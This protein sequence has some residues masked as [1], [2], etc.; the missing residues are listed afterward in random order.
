MMACL[1]SMKPIGDKRHRLLIRRVWDV[2][3]YYTVCR[4]EN[5]LVL[6]APYQRLGKGHMSSG[7]VVTASL[8]TFPVRV[9]QVRY[10]V[11]SLLLQTRRPDKIIL[12]LAESQFPG[13][14]TPENLRDLC[15]YGLEIRFCD[16]LRSHKKYYYT[17]QEQRENEL[18]VT[19]DDDII[20]HPHTIE[21][22]LETHKK[23]PE[24]IICSQVRIMTFDNAGK[25]NPY[26][27]W[28]TASD[29]M[30]APDKNH[31]PLTG[32]GCLYPYG[33]M[34]PVTF[35]KEKIR[36][37]AP[38][39]DDLWIGV[40]ARMNGT[41]ICIPEKVARIFS[42][43]HDSQTENLSQVNCIGDGNDATLARLQKEFGII[44]Q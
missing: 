42:V 2:L 12:W 19:F 35:D 21:R 4:I 3:R 15:A 30:D 6:R 1:E 36:T 40:L 5:W 26:N 38:T 33:V 23:H 17:L 10:S 14:Q 41:L 11:I 34:P 20:Y 27:Q 44:A 13:R 16:D 9:K 39:A 43:V 31:T 32:S 7:K 8:T 28:N 18:V 24:C 22:L 29:G 37:I 25:L